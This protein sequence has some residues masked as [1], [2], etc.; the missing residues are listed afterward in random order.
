MTNLISQDQKN[1]IDDFCTK[2]QIYNY[3]INSDGSIDVNGHVDIY[4]G[5]LTKL[6]IVFNNV[7]QS[8]TCSHNELT[9]LEGAPKKVG[10]DF[11][12]NHNK[13]TSMKH[14]P[15]WVGGGVWCNENRLS[16]LSYSP[17]HVGGIFHCG[18]NRITSL[19]GLPNRI[20]KTL[21]CYDN[22]ITS[23]LGAPEYIGGDLC[24]YI[25]QLHNTYTGGI[26]IE[27]GG[28]INIKTSISDIAKLPKMISDNLHHIRLILKYQRHFY[29]W[30]DDLSL[31]ED[32][33]QELLDEIADGL[34]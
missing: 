6:P 16:S 14:S 3:T 2:Y 24:A 27:V 13:L 31:N 18:E 15:L 29:I 17:K 5:E 30:N 33:L 20:G 25:N 23:L 32:A 34:E 8:F 28:N 1:K 11:H 26:D 7:S 22:L 10:K 9:T 21:L 12:C 19:V 4:R